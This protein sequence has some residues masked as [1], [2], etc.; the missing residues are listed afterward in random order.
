ML[1]CT[2]VI[3]KKKGET[4]QGKPIIVHEKC[5][6]PAAEYTVGG[7]LAQAKA[8]LCDRHKNLADRECFV[9]QN[10]FASGRVSSR[11]KA[12]R[13]QQSRLPGTGVA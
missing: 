10:G 8:T 1:K 5:V 6:A 9:S 2:K 4:D 12:K 3:R 7:L 13:Y 11:E